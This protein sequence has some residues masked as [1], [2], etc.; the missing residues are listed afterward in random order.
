MVGIGGGV[1]KGALPRLLVVDDDERVLRACA[2]GLRSQCSVIVAANVQQAQ[3]LLSDAAPSAALVDLHLGDGSGIDVIKELKAIA[4]AATALLMSGL[5][6]FDAVV[7]AMRAG[8][9]DIILKPFTSSQVT[10]MLHARSSPRP[11]AP[12][13]T[14]KFF[15]LQRA[16]IPDDLTAREREIAHS[17]ACG[18]TAREIACNLR[19]SFHTIRTHIKNIYVK[20]G[21]SNRVELVRWVELESARPPRD[22]HRDDT[23]EE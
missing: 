3:R 11:A 18:E 12:K 14:S 6:S 17:L 20:V 23:G 15:S 22:P 8:A 13:A 5:M 1:P 21:V 9:D 16:H 2:R 19:L 7:A 10:A 4:P